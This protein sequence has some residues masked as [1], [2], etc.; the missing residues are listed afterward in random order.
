M[1][2]FVKEKRNLFSHGLWSCGDYSNLEFNSNGP[3]SAVNIN[4]S[5]DVS[6]IGYYCAKFITTG[7]TD[8]YIGYRL[9]D[10]T[11]IVGKTIQFTAYI[12]NSVELQIAVYQY[13][14]G[15]YQSQT[16]TVPVSD[17]FVPSSINIQ[18]NEDAAHLLFRITNRSS[19]Y[20]ETVLYTDNWSL[21]E[22]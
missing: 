20:N 1:I 13:V 14:N 12:K 19:N 16:A 11:D 2:L 21:E 15:S 8:R 4:K 22:V 6:N 10:L 18:I 7:D 17:T 5:N 3:S 9:N